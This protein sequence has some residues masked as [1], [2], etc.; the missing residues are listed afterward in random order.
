MTIITSEK[1]LEEMTKQW[2]LDIEL[3]NTYTLKEVYEHLYS[4]ENSKDYV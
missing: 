4:N 2:E 3:G 1:A